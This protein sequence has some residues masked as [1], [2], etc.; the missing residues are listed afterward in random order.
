MSVSAAGAVQWRNLFEGVAGWA[1]AINGPGMGW[2]EPS[3]G[4]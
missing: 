3:L 1:L 2:F 4:S